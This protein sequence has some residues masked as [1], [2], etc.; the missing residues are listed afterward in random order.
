MDVLD[1][2]RRRRS[3]R[4]YKATPVDDKTLDV[5]LEAGRMA[6]SWGNTQTSRFVVVKD[7]N[8]KMQLAENA[9]RPSNRGTDA[10]K[11]APIVIAACAELNKAGFRDGAPSTDKGG[12][13]FMFD[14]ALALENMV[15]AAESFGLGTLFVG[16]MDARKAEVILGVPQG[17]AFVILMVLGY[18]DEQPEARPRKGAAEIVFKDRFLLRQ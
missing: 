6:P 4:A 14:A 5:I 17:Y 11:K 13:W 1:A 10:V 2:I 12:Y 9:L 3:I 8:I 15:L 18:P 7:Q 16:G